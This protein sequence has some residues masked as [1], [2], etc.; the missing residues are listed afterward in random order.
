MPRCVAGHPGRSRR[1]PGPRRRALGRPWTG[2][3]TARRARP[4][5]TARAP[6]TIVASRIGQARAVGS[7][8]SGA[9]ADAHDIGHAAHPGPALEGDRGLRDEHLG[10]VGR[11]QA[12]GSGRRRAAASRAAR[13]RDRRRSPS[14]AARSTG[15]VIPGSSIPTVVALT[16]RSADRSAVSNAGSASATAVREPVPTSRKRSTSAVADAA[17]RFPT[18]TRRAPARRQAKTTAWAAPPAPATTTSAPASGRPIA[19]STPAWKPGASRVEPDQPAVVGPDDVV[20]GADGPRLVLDLVDEAGDDP[21]VRRGHPEAEPVR[22]A[23]LCDRALHGVRLELEQDVPRV[24][25]GRVERGVVHDLRV[26]PL[27][28]A[29]R[30]APTRRVIARG[31]AGGGRAR[32]SPGRS[33]WG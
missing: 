6:A 16:A 15:M 25:A 22:P 19:S 8:S 5:L 9:T 2:A 12:T 11:P 24:D 32:P 7:A 3:G 13:R 23:R 33:R 17:V 10:A 30:A 26:P 29:S 18:V 1:S 31:S 21:L 14:R 27:A 20:H 4:R 28:A